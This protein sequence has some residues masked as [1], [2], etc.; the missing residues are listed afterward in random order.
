VQRDHIQGEVREL[1]IK[2][3]TTAIEQN[4]MKR[5]ASL[6][7]KMLMSQKGN[8]TGCR[9]GAR[10]DVANPAGKTL[11]DLSHGTGAPMYLL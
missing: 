7:K 5:A 1:Q 6:R 3:E 4:L 8:S 11:E 10:G 9:G 2:T